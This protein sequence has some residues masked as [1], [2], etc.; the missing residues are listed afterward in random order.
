MAPLMRSCVLLQMLAGMGR[1]RI[2]TT[3]TDGEGARGG[4]TVGADETT[5]ENESVT[6]TGTG[7]WT[8]TAPTSLPAA[9]RASR[10]CLARWTSWTF[11]CLDCT[12]MGTRSTG[13]HGMFMFNGF[14]S[15]DGLLY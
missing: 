1:G 8:R 6:A 4:V 15:Q 13:D 12:G 5:T 10:K 14:S 2:G 11:A 9:S 7:T 3:T